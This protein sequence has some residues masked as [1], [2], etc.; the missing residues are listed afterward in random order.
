MY[1]NPFVAGMCFA[2]LLE[3][4]FIFLYVFFIAV[5]RAIRKIIFKGDDE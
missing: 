4:G 1:I 5:W 3:F 2:I